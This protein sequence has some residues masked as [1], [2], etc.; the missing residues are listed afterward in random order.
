[1]KKQRLISKMLGL[2]LAGAVTASSLTGCSLDAFEP[3]STP[4]TE[5]SGK[6]IMDVPC[7]NFYTTDNG[8]FVTFLGHKDNGID[9]N[10]YTFIDHKDYKITYSIS[11]ED[12]LSLMK[13]FKNNFIRNKYTISGTQTSISEQKTEKLKKIIESYNPI[14]VEDYVGL[15]TDF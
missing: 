14:S 1:M 2:A 15:H 9:H 11:R 10:D 3:L 4:L 8:Y 13:T 6:I 12:Y 5:D 7:V